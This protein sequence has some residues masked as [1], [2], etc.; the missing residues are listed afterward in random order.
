[1]FFELL[2]PTSR[3]IQALIYCFCLKISIHSTD[4]NSVP[5][6][7]SYSTQVEK[8]SNKCFLINE[9]FSVSVT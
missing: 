9:I 7:L 5:E 1:M 6:K 8:Y 2:C 3:S 4:D